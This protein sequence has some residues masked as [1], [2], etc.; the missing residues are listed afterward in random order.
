MTALLI[1]AGKHVVASVMEVSAVALSPFSNDVRWIRGMVTAIGASFGAGRALR[2]L[3]KMSRF[4]NR[5][6][7]IV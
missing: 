3:S 1:G 2:L 6:L 7:R 5:D 4:C